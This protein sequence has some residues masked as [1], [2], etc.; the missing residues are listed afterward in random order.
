MARALLTDL[1]PPAARGGA[2][3]YDD[4]LEWFDR[5]LA[6]AQAVWGE[7]LLQRGMCEG[8]ASWVLTYARI[9]GAKIRAGGVKDEALVARFQWLAVLGAELAVGAGGGAGRPAAGG[10]A[11]LDPRGQGRRG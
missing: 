11:P 1:K 9:L 4:A 5:A 6:A 8:N 7:E 2:G 10:G 3:G